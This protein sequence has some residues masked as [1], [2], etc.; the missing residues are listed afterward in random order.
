MEIS[1]AWILVSGDNDIFEKKLEIT[2][3]LRTIGTKLIDPVNN[4]IETKRIYLLVW[5][6]FIGIVIPRA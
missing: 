4:K 5:F 6:D 3:P 1:L 2:F